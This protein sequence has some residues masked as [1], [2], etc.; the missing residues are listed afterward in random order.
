MKKR[1]SVYVLSILSI[2]MLSITGCAKEDDPKT[3]GE[4]DACITSPTIATVGQSVSFT[5]CSTGATTYLWEF[6]DGSNQTSN[7][8][9]TTHTFTA[10]GNYS[11]TLT[12][13]NDKGSNTAGTVVT[14]SAGTGTATSADYAGVYNTTSSCGGNPFSYSLTVAAN[15]T[16]AITINNLSNLSGLGTV[17][18]TINGLVVTIPQ[19][20]PSGSVFTVNGSGTLSSNKKTLNLSY[21]ISDGGSQ[22][23]CTS[24]GTKP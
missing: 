4:P 23:N 20:Q 3:E 6:G 7:S 16:N 13:T 22:S 12:V 24:N 19:Q 11:V 9:N 5:S 10:P 14:V 2:A 8:A 1:F 15:G 21:T 17:N 18:A